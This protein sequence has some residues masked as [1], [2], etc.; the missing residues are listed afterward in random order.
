VTP[1]PSRAT[2]PEG[3]MLTWIPIT[4]DTVIPNDTHALALRRWRTDGAPWWSSVVPVIVR[5]VGDICGETHPDRDRLAWYKYD[6][7]QGG[8]ASDYSHYAL[9]SGLG[10]LPALPV[11][12]PDP[13]DALTD[14]EFGAKY[15]LGNDER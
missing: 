10:E 9:T 13:D 5:R 12:K 15:G 7:T 3:T 4:P 14:A 11:E 6:Y 2:P 8:R 1:T